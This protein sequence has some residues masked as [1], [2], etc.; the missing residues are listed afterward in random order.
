LSRL[1]A[2]V[3]C[4]GLTTQTI[5]P[6]RGWGQL[7]RCLAMGLASHRRS[8]PC[9]RSGASGRHQRESVSSTYE[10]CSHRPQHITPNPATPRRRDAGRGQTRKRRAGSV[11]STHSVGAR[12]PRAESR[13]TAQ[14]ERSERAVA[15]G[16]QAEPE[17]PRPCVGPGSRVQSLA[18]EGGGE[19]R[20]RQRLRNLIRCSRERFSHEPVDIGRERGD[21]NDHACCIYSVW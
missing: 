10:R 5:P 13:P 11:R 7:R 16:R 12:P 20:T 2:D 9:G 21:S 8:G 6:H 15:W 3:L 19:N 17:R 14:S 1:S 4:C 18:G